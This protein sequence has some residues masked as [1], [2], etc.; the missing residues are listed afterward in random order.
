MTSS[1]R[2]LTRVL[3][4]GAAVL[5]LV[6]L[7][8]GTGGAALALSPATGNGNGPETNNANASASGNTGSGTSNGN[9][10]P[11]VPANDKADSAN[12]A[13]SSGGGTATAP[14]RAKKSSPA[15]DNSVAPKHDKGNASTR[16]SF[17]KPQPVSNADQNTGGANGGCPGTTKGD[18]CST[19]DGAKSGNGNGNGKSV[20][21]P[22]AGCVGKA[23][24]K[25]PSGQYK[26]GSDHNAGYEC[27]RNHGIGRTNPAHTG[28]KDYTPPAP[29]IT[30]CPDGTIKQGD[31]CVPPC[32]AGCTPT[33]PPVTPPVTPPTPPVSC[34]DATVQQGNHCLPLPDEAVTC[35]EDMVK[36]NGKCVRPSVVAGV[37]A[38]APPKAAEPQVLGVQR[39][40]PS[41]GVLPATGAGDELGLLGVA[42]FVLVLG[43]VAT[44]FMRRRVTD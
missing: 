3:G 8:L 13:T 44:L 15:V 2:A 23:D 28:C 38:F 40:A 10:I 35:P 7:T 12:P 1:M 24:N 32:P 29:P 22:C 6:I 33:K 27:D 43:G 42:G 39:V 4:T 34:P 9:G 36:Q 37:E 5:L 31:K 41:E 16:G 20:G 11:G 25:N 19:R 30:T 21:K 14:G 17:D 26:N 18:Y